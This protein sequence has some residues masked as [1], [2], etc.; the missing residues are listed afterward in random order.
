VVAGSATVRNPL[1]WSSCFI[2]GGLPSA[3]GAIFM[4]CQK[5][6]FMRFE[7]DRWAETPVTFTNSRSL[8]PIE[9][10]RKDLYLYSPTPV[11]QSGGKKPRE[12]MTC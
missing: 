6:P 9:R 1:S 5:P 8:K 11:S 3:L 12:S 10:F 7:L 2:I 4:V